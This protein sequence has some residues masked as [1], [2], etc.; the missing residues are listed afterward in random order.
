MIVQFKTHGYCQSYDLP[1]YIYPWLL[2]TYTFTYV[3]LSDRPLLHNRERITARK[4][5][6]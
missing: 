5:P 6:I 1:I 4:R 2:L 3:K